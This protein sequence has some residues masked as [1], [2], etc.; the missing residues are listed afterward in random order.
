MNN[1]RVF[2]DVHDHDFGGHSLSRV[3]GLGVIGTVDFTT[4]ASQLAGNESM[5][6]F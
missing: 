6:G 2:S 3:D 5:G 4:F 1:F